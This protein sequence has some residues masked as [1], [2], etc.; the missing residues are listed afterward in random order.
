V[1]VNAEFVASRGRTDI[2]L[3]RCDISFYCDSIFNFL[4]HQSNHSLQPRSDRIILGL[5]LLI[6]S[7]LVMPCDIL[8]ILSFIC[9]NFWGLERINP[10]QSPKIVAYEEQN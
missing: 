1:P 4:R 10:F 5:L 9:Y 3:H 7:S 8:L 6:L 2:K